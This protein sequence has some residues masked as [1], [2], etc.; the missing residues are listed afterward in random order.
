MMTMLDYDEFY[1]SNYPRKNTRMLAI[2]CCWKLLLLLF[3]YFSK[4]FLLLII[5]FTYITNVVPSQSSIAEFSTPMPFPFT[6][7]RFP[8]LLGICFPWKIKSLHD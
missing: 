3:L 7:E 5:L 6:S 8:P 2:N 4:L 1:I